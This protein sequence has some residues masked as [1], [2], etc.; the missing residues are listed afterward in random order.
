MYTQHEKDE[1]IKA[2]VGILY[3]LD[4][5]PVFMCVGVDKVVLDSL[6]PIVSNLLTKKYNIP[7]FIYG[8]L[9]YNI[10]A[11]NLV[12]AKNFIDIMHPKHKVIIIDATIGEYDEVGKVKVVHGG[13]VPA[14]YSLDN[15]KS[16]GDYAIL[17]VVGTTGIR[18][19]IVL[20]NT[21]MQ[22]VLQMA[23]FI[24]ECISKAIDKVLM[25]KEYENGKIYSII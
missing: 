2:M 16:M 5:L 1:L 12:Y 25:L 9:E 17:G 23:E 18:G 19:K 6:A 22:L 15:P 20:N 4:K 3:S 21:S 11:K 14:V 24:A 13:V 8:S 10:T 7:A